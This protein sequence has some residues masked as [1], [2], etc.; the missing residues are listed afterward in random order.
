MNFASDDRV[1]NWQE[2]IGALHS[3]DVVQPRDD[4]GLHLRSPYVFRGADVAGWE[5]DTSLQRLLRHRSGS[6]TVIEHS[7]IRSFRKYASAG[8]FDQKSEW[9]VLAVAQHNGLPTRCLDWTSSPLVAAH[10]A[11]GDEKYKD[12]D[13]CIWCLHA[14][15]LRRENSVA[16]MRPGWVFDTRSLESTFRDLA[17]FDATSQQGKHLILWEPPSLD[18]R[19]ANQSGLLSLMNDSNA[20]QHQH[21]VTLSRKNQSLMRRIVIDR[22]A[23]AEIRDML[24]QNS[25]SE[26]TLF[27]DL[28]G[29][30]SWLK[31]YYGKSWW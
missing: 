8:S 19:I 30:C 6:D 9:Y 14:G 17:T 13:G 31:R 22:K 16:A 26:R 1:A 28:P 29:L 21:L 15:A 20:S 24:D 18:S 10:F 3:R 27:P 2:L 5:L 25:I 11:C 23:K 7:L 4:E 12:E